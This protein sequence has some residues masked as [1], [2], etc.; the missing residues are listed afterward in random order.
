M[1]HN[2][3]TDFVNEFLPKQNIKQGFIITMDYNIELIDDDTPMR[4]EQFQ[5]AVGGYIE[6][7]NY[8]TD[9]NFEVIVDEEGLVKNKK[10]NYLALEITG[11][12]L[13]GD[14]LILRKGLLK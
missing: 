13:R 10:L 7:V 6:L 2:T 11:V 8:I 3:I 14:V 4:L 12:S 1:K 5:Y 9:D